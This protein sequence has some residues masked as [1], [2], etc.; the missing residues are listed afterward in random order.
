MLADPGRMHADVLGINR[1][2][3]NFEHELLGG[4]RIVLVAIVAEREVSEF[5]LSILPYASGLT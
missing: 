4:S 2:I 5:H 1:L 3:A